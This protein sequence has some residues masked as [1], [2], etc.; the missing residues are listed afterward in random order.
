M[1]TDS[2]LLLWNSY[3][4][5]PPE[6]VPIDPE[7]KKFV[8]SLLIFHHRPEVSRVIFISTPHR[9]SEIASNWIGSLETVVAEIPRTAATELCLTGVP[10][11]REH[12][13]NGS[14]RQIMALTK[15]RRGSRKYAEYCSASQGD[16]HTRKKASNEHHH[17]A[18]APSIMADIPAENVTGE[19]KQTDGNQI[20]NAQ[21]VPGS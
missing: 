6:E 13:R 11:W 5:K 8:E 12:N 19:E 10:T 21:G 3:F 2:N 14:Y 20:R 15:T 9:G 7:T 16:S 18:E 17:D 1:V 4:A